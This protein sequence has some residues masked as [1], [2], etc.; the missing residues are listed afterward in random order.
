MAM[1]IIASRF[2]QR[3]THLTSDGAE[4]SFRS[5]ALSMLSAE[6]SGPSSSSGHASML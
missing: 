1:Q 3:L 2:V 6:G 4:V 5:I